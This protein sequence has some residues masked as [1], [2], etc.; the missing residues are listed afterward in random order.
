MA[1][2]QT[3]KGIWFY[4]FQVGKR[5]FRKQGFKNRTEAEKAETVKK[6]DVLR[7]A[8]RGE[9]MNNTLR[10]S[11]ASDMFFEEY[12]RPFKRT[13][14]ADRAQIRAIKTYFK[15][16]R[17]RDISIR[18]VEAFR[19]WLPKNVMTRYGKPIKLHTVNHYHA[20]LKAII[21]WCKKR[22]LYFGEN[23]A[24]GVEM[25]DIPKAKVRFLSPEEEKRLTPV[26]ARDRRLWPYYVIALHTGMRLGEVRN[27]RVKDVIRHPKPMLFIPN[28]KT[29]RSRHVPL[30]GIALEVV[31]ERAKGKNPEWLLLEGVGNVTISKW[32]NEACYAAQ[33][34]DAFTF[35]CLR[36]TFAG[37]MLGE[38]VPIYLVSKILGHSTVITTESHYGH[39]DKSIFSR[40]IHHI[41]SVMTMPDRQIF[42]DAMAKNG[43]VVNSAVNSPPEPHDNSVEIVQNQ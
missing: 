28:S 13:W 6:A 40:E 4:R 14:R 12:A 20:Q 41:G 42:A 9:D 24:W 36:H 3:A 26:V 38:G 34:R 2:K 23:P 32:F 39:L 22:R 1:A 43:Q 15:D 27:I 30:H 18:D 29:S 25:A 33:V 10:L 16:R 17:I 31:L 5:A 37:H 19:L 7:R 35:H 11:E 8:A 21:N